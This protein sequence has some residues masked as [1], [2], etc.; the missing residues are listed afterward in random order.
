M[1]QLSGTEVTQILLTVAVLLGSARLCG[2]LARRWHQPAV[3]GEIIAGILLGPT[4]L[5]ALAPGVAGYLFPASGP[6]ALVLSGITNVALVLFMLV[7]GMEVDLSAAWRQGRSAAAVSL[8]GLLLPFSVG[9]GLAWMAPRVLGAEPGADPLVFSLFLATA[10]AISALPVIVRTLLDLDLFRSDLGMVVVPAAI[11]NDTVGWLVFAVVIGMTDAGHARTPLVATLLG[12]VAFFVLTLTVVRWALDFLLPRLHAFASWPGGV[13]GFTATFGLLAAALT[14]WLGVHAVFGAFV[15]G[16]A[17][18][19]SRHLRERTRA[20]LDQFVSF[21]F[22]PL[23][24]ATVG[25]RVDLLEHFD[26]ALVA[27]VLTVAVV[28]KVAGGTLG[29]RLSGIAPRQAWATGV[30]LMSSGTMGII[31]GLVALRLGIIGERL[32]V[33]LVVMALVTSVLTGPILGWLVSSKK[34]RRCLDFV[35]ARAFLPGL[36]ADSKEEVI[37]ALS[38]AVA[39]AHGLDPARVEAAVLERERLMATGLEK[40]VAVPH[41]RLDDLSSPIV[42]VATCE[43]GV[44]FDAV[45]GE[46]CRIIV[47]VLTPAADDQAQLEILADVART[48][49]RGSVQRHVLAARTFVELRAA[50]LTAE[51]RGRDPRSSL[52]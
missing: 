30:A 50:V 28:G 45:D 32:F 10:L 7:A 23:F 36:V 33:A 47:L 34:P 2:E 3:L 8:S 21:V 20:T 12:T 38:V 29:A 5:G 18:G 4:V 17:I 44:E 9:F 31:L 35:V 51:P 1:D 43:R 49:S 11:L 22:A 27:V 25:L 46:P 26:P 19:D 39:E 37:R 52:V 40:G 6:A 41:A 15:F 24:F 42:G 16:I 48:L 14:E 13:L